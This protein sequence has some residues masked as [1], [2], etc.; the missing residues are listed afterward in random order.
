MKFIHAGDIHLGNPFVGL[1]NIPNWTQNLVQEAGNTAFQRLVAD[2]IAEDVDFILLPGDLF[3]GGSLDAQVILT[4]LNAF[5]ELKAAKIQVIL[6]YGNHDFMVGQNKDLPWPDN[7]F[8]LASDKVESRQLTSKHGELVTFSG[9]SYGQQHI[10]ADMLSQFPSRNQASK[11]HIGL[12]HGELGQ[13]G[14]GD[15]APFSL[16]AMNSKHYDYWA[17]GHIHVRQTLQERPFIGYSGDLQGLNKNETG[18]KGYYLVDDASGQLQGQF[19]DVAPVIWLQEKL[20]LPADLAVNE[21]SNYIRQ[22]VQGDR[23]NFALI[24]LALSSDDARIQ[25]LLA[26]GQLQAQLMQDSRTQDQWYIWELTY[27]ATTT[28]G[29]L[30]QLAQADWQAS[31]ATVF[32]LDNLQ[33]LGLKQVVDSELLHEFLQVEKLQELQTAV[34][35]KIQTLARGEDSDEN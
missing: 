3:D 23:D 15:Y 21:L 35:L 30:P 16:T 9:F 22:H 7:V 24:T 18:H 4:V 33:A 1:R 10:N 31:V 2:A 19:I 13:P 5:E 20:T 29:Q 27:L 14:Q 32:T 28:D 17:L 8:V 12:Y 26:N 34:S 6:A 25:S 11:Y